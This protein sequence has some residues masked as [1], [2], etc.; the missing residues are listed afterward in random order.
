MPVI[1]PTQGSHEAVSREDSW[2][3]SN[4]YR[5]LYFPGGHYTMTNQVVSLDLTEET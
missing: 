5:T 3:L 4:F 2:R 1:A